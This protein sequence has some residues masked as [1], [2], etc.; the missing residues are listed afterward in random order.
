MLHVDDRQ[1]EIADK[2]TDLVYLV[3]WLRFR[4]C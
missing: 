2:P 3:G 4:A 1:H